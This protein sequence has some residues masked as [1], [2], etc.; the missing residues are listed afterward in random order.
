M[1]TKLWADSGDSHFLEPA[2]L[3]YQIM[4]K[5]Q[6]D[7]MPR[8]RLIN[9]NEELIEVDGKSFTRTL[10]RLMTAKGATGETIGEMSARPPGSGLRVEA[11]SRQAPVPTSP[12]SIRRQSPISPLLPTPAKSRPAR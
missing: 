5:A 11:S 7:R 12:C 8:T 4:P 1:T 6:A 10:P 9:E 2:D 3:W